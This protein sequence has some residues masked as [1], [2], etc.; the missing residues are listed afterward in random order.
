MCLARQ[1][2]P[3]FSRLRRLG[4]SAP[5]TPRIGAGSHTRGAHFCQV[6]YLILQPPHMQTFQARAWFQLSSLE[7]G[8]KPLTHAHYS[9]ARDASTRTRK[10]A[11]AAASAERS[12]PH[13]TGTHTP[14]HAMPLHATH[15]RATLLAHARG[16]PLGRLERAGGRR[17]HGAARARIVPEVDTTPS[18]CSTRATSRASER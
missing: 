2:S 18:P 12:L 14:R 17:R 11:R 1:K 15:A 7:T 4:G 10:D 5:Q 3:K 6:L 9:A 16:R 8:V 13:T